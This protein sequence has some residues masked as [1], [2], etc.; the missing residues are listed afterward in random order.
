[1]PPPARRGRPTPPRARAAKIDNK[2]LERFP[3]FN[4]FRKSTRREEKVRHIDEV[5]TPVELL[6]DSYQQLKNE[7][8][9]D[10]LENLLNVSPEA[11]ERIVIDLLVRMGYGG[12]LRDAGT[13]IGSAGDEGVDGVIKEDKLGLDLVYVQAKRWKGTVG[14]PVVQAFVGALQGKKARKGIL[15][16]TSKFTQDAVSYAAGIET[17]VALVDGETLSQLMIDYDL[18]VS[19]KETYQVK[20]IDTD[21]FAQ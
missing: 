6:E 12:S 9:S 14:R 13:A 7:L 8:A 10:V 21:Y 4:E 1:M 18:G 5:R 2:Y 15:I 17:R 11:F 19:A 20:V 3:T 16:T